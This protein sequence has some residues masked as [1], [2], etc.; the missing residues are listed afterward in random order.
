M[1]LSHGVRDGTPVSH[2]E[3]P[4]L[5]PST[6]ARRGVA[7][8]L[9]RCSRPQLTAVHPAKTIVI[10]ACPFLA[11]CGRVDKTTFS[12]V[13][14][15]WLTVGCIEQEPSR[16]EMRQALVQVVGQGASMGMETDILELT[17]SFTIGQGVEAAVEEVRDLVASQ[18][19]C[20]T[21]TVQPGH[22]S[23]D[24]GELSDLCLYR[25]RTYAGVVSVDFERRAD[26]F[27]VNHSYTGFTNGVVTLDG[28]ADVTWTGGTRTISTDLSFES[29]GD[30]LDVQAERTQVFSVCPGV[31]AICVSIDGQRQWQNAAGDWDMSIDG[32]ELRSIDPVPE[33][34]TYSVTTP[35]GEDVSMTFER[36]D[37][38]TIAVVVS[39]GRHEFAFH[40]TAAGQVNE[41]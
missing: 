23:I 36:V 1:V 19:P 38:D 34:G 2:P 29:G 28:T 27:F 8:Y 13:C 14:L 31:E 16:A 10:F 26:V 5:R 24:F 40:V 6:V 20:S 22:L 33:S 41:G 18:I 4:A 37:Q 30:T 12:A 17:T 32:V 11:Q 15:A 9:R 39:G 7:V 35:K 25:G 21:V 3:G